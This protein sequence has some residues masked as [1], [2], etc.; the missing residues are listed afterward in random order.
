MASEFMNQVRVA[1]RLRHYSKRTEE[2]YCQWIRRYILF[3]NKQHPKHMNESHIEAFLSYLAIQRDV[4]PST[5]NSALNALT[6]L[7]REV[8][9]I[10]LKAYNQ[11]TRTKPKKKLPV[12]LT[13]EEIVLF[14]QHIKGQP[15]L[16][17]ALMYG[18][19][20]R[21]MET[22]RLRYKDIDLHKLCVRVIDGKGGKDRVV[23]LSK[24][25]AN[26]LAIQMEKV[27]T[28]YLQDRAD[29]VPG[30]YLPH[31]LER[32]YPN[33]STSLAWQYLFPSNRLNQDRRTQI[34]RRHHID[35]TSVQKAVKRAI[36]EAGIQKAASCHSLRHSFATH[37]LERG[38]D[39]RTAQEQLGHSDVK[40]T[41]IY[42]HVLNRGGNSVQSPLDDLSHI[43]NL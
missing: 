35:E 39:I 6:F 43:L 2:S 42:T 18:S 24:N 10:E 27:E 37:L 20:L 17:A 12:F 28:L 30:V 8:L 23:T 9:Q 13:Q 22:L 14:F 21:L 19:G 38:A 15:K 40:T 3:H 25:T 32:K 29:N 31:A 11:F 1:I 5:Q 26:H 4:S 33:A 7:Y 41:Q 36:Y 34:R 16:A